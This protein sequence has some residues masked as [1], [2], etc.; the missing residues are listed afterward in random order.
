LFHHERQDAMAS[1]DWYGEA[2]KA[3]RGCTP[4]VFAK[5]VQNIEKIRSYLEKRTKEWQRR[6]KTRG[7]PLGHLY[8]YQKKGD[9]GEGVCKSMKLEGLFL[10]IGRNDAESM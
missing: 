1:Q 3:C 8:D 5:S 10:K 2:R 9:A 4:A 6:A 7:H